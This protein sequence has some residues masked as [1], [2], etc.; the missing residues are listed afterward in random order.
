MPHIIDYETIQV[1]ELPTIWSPVQWDLT[2]EEKA[3]ELKTQA[4]A[5]LLWA[6][7]IPEA[8]LRL[9]LSEADIQDVFSPPENYDPEMQGEWDESLITFAFKRKITLKEVRRDADKIVLV[10]HL[11]DLGYWGVEIGA[12]KVTI[13]RI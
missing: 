9:L 6:A 11:A 12:E 13:E 2:P 3:D 1:D 8:I 10:Y 7:N 5:S 4:T